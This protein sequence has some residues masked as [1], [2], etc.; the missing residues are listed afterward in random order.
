MP[1]A[2]SFYPNQKQLNRAIARR[3]WV[4]DRLYEENVI[5]EQEATQAKEEPLK[6]NFGNQ[7]RSPP[8]HFTEHVRIALINHLGEEVVLLGGLEV[9]TTL[10]S[11]LQAI[12]VKALKQGLIAY[13]RRHGWRGAI[14]TIDLNSAEGQEWQ[15]ELTKVENPAGLGDWQLRLRCHC[16][17]S[18]SQGSHRELCSRS[19]GP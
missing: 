10:D 15:S 2:P 5:T 16:R 19:E 1:K 3:N 8:D 13:D 9:K 4:I 6:F 12:A 17:T 11:K 14:T 7:E 18:L